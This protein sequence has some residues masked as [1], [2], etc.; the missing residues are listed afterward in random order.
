VQYLYEVRVLR[1][2]AR[3][4]DTERQLFGLLC[5]EDAAIARSIVKDVAARTDDEALAYVRALLAGKAPEVQGAPSTASGNVAGKLAAIAA[6]LTPE[7][8]AAAQELLSNLTA[9]ERSLMEAQ[10][11]RMTASDAT[12]ALRAYLAGATPQQ[13]R[14]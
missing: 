1:L 4:T 5:A 2:Q 12:A 11:A 8:I 9:A 13:V 6:L 14:S 3:L 10:L 7:E